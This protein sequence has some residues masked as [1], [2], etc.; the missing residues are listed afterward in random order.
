MS[1]RRLYTV[2]RD[3]YRFVCLLTIHIYYFLPIC[4]PILLLCVCLSVCLFIKA[5]RLMSTGLYV[6]IARV[7]SFVFFSFFCDIQSL[8]CQTAER[9]PVK[10]ISKV[11]S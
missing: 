3:V 2:Q 5:A 1:T 9:R 10:S 8:F 4:L 6:L 7:L 11:W